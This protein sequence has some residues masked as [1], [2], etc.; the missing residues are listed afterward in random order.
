MAEY[1]RIGQAS[2]YMRQEEAQKKREA[3][4]SNRIP[5]TAKEKQLEARLKELEEEVRKLKGIKRYRVDVPC[6]LT[7][8]VEA[9]D[10]GDALRQYESRRET[11]CDSS[12]KS[13]PEV[14]EIVDE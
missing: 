12:H 13:A 4:L 5:V 8:Y 11:V 6:V 3:E 2:D 7:Y 1:G 14:K 10:T 9:T